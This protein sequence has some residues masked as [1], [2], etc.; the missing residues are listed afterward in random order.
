MRTG[1]I[2]TALA[3]AM[4]A[5]LA[6]AAA[7]PVFRAGLVTD[8][9]IDATP[10]ACDRARQAFEL[11]KSK[12]VDLVFHLGDLAT[13]YCPV[14]WTNWVRT[15]EGVWPA[16]ANRPKFFYVSAS[17]DMWN[18]GKARTREDVY[19]EFVKT[20]VGAHDINDVCEF[21][22]YP[23]LVFA[24]FARGEQQMERMIEKAEKT[25]P[26]KPVFVL[27]HEPG[28]D[29][30]YKS[31][32]WGNA[33]SRQ[34]FDRHPAVVHIGGHAHSAIRCERDIWQGG[35]TAIDAACLSGWSTEDV[36]L[37]S[38]SVPEAGASVLEV[39][40]DKLVVRRFDVLN[41]GCE[42]RP[43]KPWTV[44]LPFDP[45]AAPYAPSARQAADRAP[46]FAGSLAVQVGTAGDRTVTVPAAKHPEGVYAYWGE[47][48]KADAAG[49]WKP[50]ALRV[51]MGDFHLP[52]ARR[53]S[54]VQIPFG[55]ELFLEGG[56]FRFVVSAEAQ[57]GL[58]SAPLVSEPV[59]I[60]PDKTLSPVASDGEVREAEK[61]GYWTVLPLPEDLCRVP[62]GTRVT[63]TFDLEG[64]DLYGCQLTVAGVK[65]NYGS[66]QM[67]AEIREPL[68]QA[69]SFVT[70]ADDERLSLKLGG[71]GQ[72]SL[73]GHVRISH[74]RLWKETKGKA[75]G[76]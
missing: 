3:G 4:L 53:A 38:Q 21:R 72:S 56:R 36:G 26:G 19:R 34:V 74:V 5:S 39:F 1:R 62:K 48:Q 42:I 69:F 54:S 47:L 9:H 16:A 70:Q 29:T 33:K 65:A 24:Q 10:G 68:R 18:A 52:E 60:R 58:K 12:G 22:G 15:I 32:L 37:P 14:G 46:D 13:V 31:L 55:H 51:R 35:H 59:D 30:T 23:I 75:G 57:S 7:E 2:M 61:R 6:V 40:A 8:T 49:V 50:F 64:R 71:F 63:L 25:H 28:M 17:H 43:E 76:K 66:A 44:P 41:G 67:P 20:V 73:S 11:F 27:D 45:K